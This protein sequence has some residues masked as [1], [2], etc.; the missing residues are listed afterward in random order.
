[1]S[2]LCFQCNFNEG[3]YGHEAPGKRIVL[4]FMCDE[5]Q[6]RKVK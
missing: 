1:M 5:L 6:S 2:L 4:V 3:I